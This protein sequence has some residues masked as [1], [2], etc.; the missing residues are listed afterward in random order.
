MTDAKITK[1]DFLGGRI[2]L[3]QPEKGYRITSDSVFLAA[4][5]NIKA[6]DKI[7]DI[8]S[9]S[10]GILACLTARL[11]ERAREIIMHGI[12][13][14]DDLITLAIKNS[15]GTIKY[16]KGDIFGD[17]PECEP[18]SYHH[19]VS[20]PP[21]YEMGK[22]NASPYKTKA[23]AQGD[24]IFDLRVWVERSLRMVRPK[25][26]ISIIHRA[27]RLDDI[28]CALSQKAGSIIIYPLYSKA[29][30]DANRVVIRAQ[31]DAKGL[32][33]LKSGLIVHKSD[34]HYTDLAENILRHAHY[35]DI[36]E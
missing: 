22:V 26:F 28:I 2:S 29:G 36:T 16:Y 35:L 4:S 13:I 1:D 34:G 31:K 9:G 20:N 15:G 5:L 12:E 6:G 8:G 10:G 27:D 32:L 19:V 17:V 3:C 21:Y 33:S 18:N 14:Q 30:K 23:V 24:G 7:L 25:G 11:G